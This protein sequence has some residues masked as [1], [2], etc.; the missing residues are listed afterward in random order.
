[1]MRARGSAYTT[2][3]AAAVVVIGIAGCSSTGG[4][5][6]ATGGGSSSGTVDT[7]RIRIAMVT[8]A[9]VGDTFWDVV[10]KGAETA[11]A[12]DNVELTYQGAEQAPDQAN[13]IQSAI[14]SKVDGIAV[15]L[16]KPDAM[17]PAI[18]A[19]ESAGIP[20]IAFNAGFDAWKSDKVLGY[21]GTDE[22]ASGRAVGDRLNA[23]GAQH[24]VCV[25]H[26]Q[27]ATSISKPGARVSPRRSRAVRRTST[28]T[29]TTC[30]PCRPR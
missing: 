28:S 21:I 1:M 30:R 29:E 22:R 18:A 4:K 2:L 6:A 27:G 16:A 20:V 14:D 5:P 11:A 12:K 7:P 24:V 26:A 9:Q 3:I 15:T 8:H 13:A 23:D 10:R 25:N 17:K 19:A